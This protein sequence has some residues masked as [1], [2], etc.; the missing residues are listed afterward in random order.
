MTIDKGRGASALAWF[1]LALLVLASLWLGVNRIFQVDEVLYAALARFMATGR[2]ATFVPNV[3]I[4]L[5]GPL[6]W[7][8]HWASDSSDVL[9]YLRL[10]FVALM[11]LNAL[12]MVKAVG[13]RVRSREGI[14]VLLLAGTLAPMWDYGFEIRHDVPLVTATLCLWWVVRTPRLAAGPKLFLAGIVAGLAEL[15]AFKGFMFSLPLLALGLY[16]AR[17]RTARSLGAFMGLALLGVS[18]ALLAGRCVH[19]LAGTWTLAWSGF[20]NAGGLTA[21]VERFSP[22]DSLGRAFS[23]AP[24]VMCGALAALAAPFLPPA[25]RTFRSFLDAPEFPEW[26]FAALFLAAFLANPT[27]FPYSLLH[28]VPA[29]FVLVVKFGERLAPLAAS[30]G[31]PARS[32]V[33]G[34]LVLLHAVPWAKSTWRHFE[35]NNE[36]QC[37]VIAAAEAMTDPASQCVF[38]GS[39]LVSCRNPP[40]EHW[41]I[42]TFTIRH[43]FD[44]SWPTVRSLLARNPTP[45]IL[46]N[47]RTSWL[48]RDDQFF[49]RDHYVA[50]AED[51]LVLGAVLGPGPGSWEA[52]A[53]GRYHMEL[54]PGPGKSEIPFEVDARPV[55]PG[56]QVLG[57][58]SHRLRV[59][60]GRQLRIAWLGPHLDQLPNLAPASHPLFVNWY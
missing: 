59:P 1:V 11:W 43:F 48:P 23:E 30:L 17:P 14:W 37:E 60:E 36:R 51:Y 15:I 2:M 54:D 22:W 6:T 28:L 8:A 21:T 35:M 24:L 50:L 20:R 12:L 34:S 58:G 40:G 46:P 32:M 44:G 26:F 25:G 19:G 18:L 45:V 16:L 41:I 31:H 53:G 7:L 9:K 33:V 47:Y 55:M 49:I 52:L 10:P 29:F 27:P 56:I 42:H 13:F 39:G 38:D 5:V 3:P 57:K 4:I